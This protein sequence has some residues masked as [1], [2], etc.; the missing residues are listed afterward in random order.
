MAK[1]LLF[2]LDGTLL[3][4]DTEAFIPVYLESITRF[5]SPH[6]EPGLFQKQLMASTYAMIGNL[7]PQPTNEEK[8]KSHFFTHIN[9]EPERWMAI[10]DEYYHKHYHEVK[11]TTCPS[12]IARE[13]AQAALARGQKIVLATNPVFPLDAVQQRMQWAGIDDLPW[14]LVTSYENSHFCK[15]HVEYYQSIL[16][17]LNAHPQDCLHIGNDVDE[18]LPAARLGIDFALVDDC[19]INPAQ[20]PL[21][22]LS[23]KGSLED[24]ARWL[25]K[26]WA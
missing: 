5:F 17:R 6:M 8:F 15:P 4:L 14:E 21:D 19:L 2:D 26:K 7:D 11:Q 25:S 20:R 23:F 9:Q 16:A 18:D 3:P 22:N 1:Y 10:F 12:P 24:L 13:I